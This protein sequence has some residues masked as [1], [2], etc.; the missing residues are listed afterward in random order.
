MFKDRFDAGEKLA[1]KLME[2][3]DNPN[4]VILAI[5]RGALEIGSVLTHELHAPLDVVLTKKIG[6]PGNPECAIGAVSLENV[7]IDKRVLEFSGDLEAH[8]KQEIAQIKALLHHRSAQYHGVREPIPLNDKIIILTD[9]GIAT[10][11]TV[12]AT[13]DLIKKQNPQKIIVAVPVASREALHLIKKKVDEV[14]CLLV[15]DIF[16]SVGQWYQ[17]FDQVSDEEAIELLQGSFV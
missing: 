1:Q 2:Y 16:M 15:P 6:Y 12:E 3:K 9:D 8:L 5:P 14:V 7:I 4:V 13:I 17:N 10:G 11:K